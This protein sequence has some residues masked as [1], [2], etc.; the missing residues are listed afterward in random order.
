MLAT[1]RNTAVIISLSLAPFAAQ[2]ASFAEGT[3]PSATVR[4][5]DLD[6]TSPAGVAALERRVKY[7]VRSVCG[8]TD[9]RDLAQTQRVA[10]CRKIAKGAADSRVQVAIANAR[11][12]TRLAQAGSAPS[13]GEAVQ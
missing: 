3:T 12:N 1:L 13:I 4:H 7:A 6:L 2:A 10:A 8:R 5:D 11:A 9:G